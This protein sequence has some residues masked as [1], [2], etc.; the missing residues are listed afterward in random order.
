MKYSVLLAFIAALSITPTTLV[1]GQS[2]RLKADSISVPCHNTD[3]FLMPIRVFDFEN[4]A[5]LQ[6]TFAWTP[7]HLQYIHIRDLNSAL[8]GVG[9]DTTTFIPQGKFTFSWTTIGGVSLPDSAVLFSVAFVRLG[10]P[11]TQAG[12]TNTPTDIVAFDDM[13]NE[14]QVITQSGKVVPLDNQPPQI[15]CPASVTV[16][17]FGPVPVD[18]IGI[19]SLIDNCSLESIGWSTMGATVG[20]HPNDPDA[21][22][23][24]FNLGESI[25][26]YTAKDVGGNTA[27]CTFSI[28][29]NLMPSDSLTLVASKHTSTCGQTLTVNISV[30]NFDSISG[31]QF[32]MGWDTNILRLDTIVNAHPSMALTSNNFGF[33]YADS[34]FVGFAWTSPLP[35]GLTLPNGSVLFALQFTVVA[36]SNGSTLITFGDF[37]T[38][39]TAFTSAVFPPEEIGFLTIQGKVTINDNEPPTMVC[40]PNVSVS[41]PPGVLTHTF[42]DLNPVT[43]TDNCSAPLQLAYVRSGSTPGSGSGSANGTYNAGTTVVTYTATDGAGNTSTC[44]FSVLV[45][46]GTPLTLILDT[47]SIDCQDSA[48]HFA[49]DVSV[50]DFVNIT[51]IQFDVTW[52]SARIRFDSVGN[53]RPGFG[54]N[55]TNFFGFTSAINGNTLKFFAGNANG[56]PNIPDDEALF[57]IYF[58]VKTLGSSPLTFTGNINAVNTSFQL[59]PVNLI[60]GLFEISDFSPPVVQCPQD[61]TVSADSG[62]CTATLQLPASDAVDA[63]SGI[64]SVASDKQGDVYPAGPTVVTFTA[65]DNA[66][67]SATCSLTVTVT[68]VTK[69][70][71]TCPQDTVLNATGTSC[72]QEVFW[73]TPQALNPCDGSPLPVVADPPSG[74]AFPVGINTV[75]LTAGSGSDTAMCSFSVTVTDAVPPVVVCPP[76]LTVAIPP[77]TTGQAV[78]ST[79]VN[80]DIPSASD[81]CDSNP[82]VTSSIPPGSV[83]SVGVHTVVLTA[84][85]ASDNTVECQFL[86]TVVDA[87]PPVVAGCPSEPLT[88]YVP[89]DSCSVTASWGDITFSDE[90]SSSVSVDPP[91]Y[92]FDLFPVGT[93]TV[94]IVGSDAG[95]NTAMCTFQVV[96]LDTLAPAISSCPTNITVVLPVDS[97]SKTISWAPPTATDNCTA[98]PTLS[99]SHAPGTTFNTGTHSVIYVA[100]DSSGNVA[101]CS[102]N[103]TVLDIVPPKFTS[104]PSDTVIAGASPCGNVVLWNFPSAE[105]NCLLDTIISTQLPTD[106]IFAQVTQVVIQ[107]I[108]A[109][110]NADTCS[111]KITLDVLI[112]P[113]AFE[114]F[115]PDITVYGCPQPVSWTPPI[116]NKKA[117]NPDTIVFTP[118]LL[119][120]DTFPLGNTAITYY[121]I[122]QSKGDTLAQKALTITVLDTVAP[123]VINCPTAPVVVHV[124]GQV[125]SGNS[126]NFILSA[127]TTGDCQGVKLSF[128]LP[129]AS[130]DCGTATVMQVQGPLPGEVFPTGGTTLAFTATDDSGNT[131]LCNVSVSVVGLEPLMVTVDPPIA[132]PGEEVMLI[133]QPLPNATYT[134][135]GPDQQ[136]YPNTNEII[137]LASGENAGRYT[138]V[139]AINGCT[140][141][142]VTV[143]V[144][145][146]AVQ[147]NADT[148]RISSS[149]LVDTFSVVAN[150]IVVPDSAFTVRPLTDPLPEG[151]TYLGDGL[152]RYQIPPN[153]RPIS[154][155]YELCSSICPDLCDTIALVT[156][157]LEEA[158]C[159]VIPN[160]FTPNGDGVNETFRIPCIASGEYPNNT[161]VIYN[162]WGDRVYEASPYDNSWDG[163]LNGQVGKNLPD[164][165]Y[166]YVFRPSPTE[167][168]RKGFIQIHR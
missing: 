104:C 80:F 115:P 71:L 16:E 68:G 29:V 133:A 92:T 137:V 22:G 48:A 141:A 86:V 101:E 130:D 114:N 120:G 121:L 154:F 90:C 161:I 146:A 43:L 144:I 85:D 142:P 6:F 134:W 163:T 105:D 2:I 138:V 84:Q 25:V 64:Q 14:L 135:M 42:N 58:T 125:I 166:Y 53:L 152:F 9:F 30:L 164:G 21:S 59:I 94:S 78:C 79:A 129:N 99:G 18:S 61:L 117:C 27:T 32:S 136:T 55:P 131:A 116:S 89:A 41:T 8:I 109:S 82:S 162:Q 158:D 73:D 128:A 112:I 126:D 150:D 87:A 123:T 37:P 15:F 54:F 118:N 66:G 35:Q 143:N 52:D 45:D 50:R 65:I 33:A 81:A 95:G 5:A 47:V 23:A 122:D 12:F 107:A 31:L 20:N 69:P 24:I 3:T 147:A 88:L 40:P 113:P 70:Q 11:A 4:V 139:A 98:T 49:V 97:C 165:V 39:Q 83:L 153:F 1:V 51:G 57:T 62:V 77:D 110:G 26:T 156:I 76:D 160:I 93:H 74:T 44:T 34:G 19:D 151:L 168:V 67:N 36:P 13:F 96:V 140:S 159:S 149:T 103:V 17:A 145:V 38:T 56:Y 132:C 124:G 155:L 46:A 102:F 63:C 111:F 167:P 7:M 119:P 100:S 108:D 10:G 106:T 148:V 157:R 91:N 72:T 60:H 28:T 127:D 75:V